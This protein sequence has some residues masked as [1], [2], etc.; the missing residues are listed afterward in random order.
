L[1]ATLVFDHP[2]IDELARYLLHRVTAT[3][4]PVAE[5]KQQVV[6]HQDVLGI[7]A[8]AALTD[9]EIEARLLERLGKS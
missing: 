3:R 7:A 8:V 4:G 6:A 1:P 2:T 5:V 9:A